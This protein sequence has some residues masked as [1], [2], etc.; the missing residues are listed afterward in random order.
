MLRL[1]DKV[2]QIKWSGHASIK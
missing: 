2:P 1:T